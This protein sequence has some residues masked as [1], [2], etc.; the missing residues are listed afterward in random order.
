MNLRNKVVVA[1]KIKS[2]CTYIKELTET[3]SQPVAEIGR[4]SSDLV[5][6]KTVHDNLK[7]KVT[8]LETQLLNDQQ[9]NF[10]N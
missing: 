5:I 1:D 10:Q 6:L 8:S 9:Y 2:L 4:L 3:V 7:N